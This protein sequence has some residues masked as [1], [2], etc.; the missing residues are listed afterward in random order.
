VQRRE[1]LVGLP[2]LAADSFVTPWSALAQ[3]QKPAPRSR[4]P[5]GLQFFTLASVASG[6]WVQYSAAM[7]LAKKIGFESLELAGLSGYKPDLIRRRAEELGLGL[8]SLH[9]G[10][11]QQRAFMAPGDVG[12]A[13]AQDA[14]YT[15]LGVV[16]VA[17]INLPLARDLGCEWGIIAAS[18][19]SNFATVDSIRRLCDAFN[20]SNELAH[21]IGL[22]LSYHMH[23]PDFEPV[24]GRMP[25]EVMIENTDSSLRYQL[26]VCWALAGG[27]DPAELI[28]QYSSRLV[29]FHLKDLTKDK[30]AATPGDGTVDFAGIFSA[31]QKVSSPLF[32]LERDGAPGLDPVQEA[33]RGYRYL[34]GLGWGTAT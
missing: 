14:V 19:H 32:Y 17:R 7:E 15:P 21:Q 13:N 8:H 12:V 1:I 31:C 30:K 29:S 33:T 23:A 24:E 4:A 16:Q 20:R 22:K 9:M 6:G 2:L 27:K 3:V 11:D 34:H 28:N 25:F 26:D 18:G 5:L 10:N